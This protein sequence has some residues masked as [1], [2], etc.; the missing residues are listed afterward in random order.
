MRIEAT[1]SGKIS[2]SAAGSQA[3]EKAK[4]KMNEQ[5]GSVIS[6]PMSRQEA[7]AILQMNVEEGKEAD[8]LDH[9]EIMTVCAPC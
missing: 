3:Y 5:M 7:I 4:E 1:K 8:P 9:E 6:R 2:G